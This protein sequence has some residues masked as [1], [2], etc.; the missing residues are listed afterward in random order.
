MGNHA[1]SIIV[2]RLRTCYKKRCDEA[3]TL[4]P[5]HGSDSRQP[6]REGNDPRSSIFLTVTC[7]FKTAWAATSPCTQSALAYYR[8]F[9]FLKMEEPIRQLRVRGIAR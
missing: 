5:Q 9:P 3:K 8:E 2:A 7:C 4:W 6:L 1:A